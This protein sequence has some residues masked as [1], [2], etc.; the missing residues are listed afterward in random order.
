M[1][2]ADWGLDPDVPTVA[3]YLQEL[4]YATHLLGK[5]HLY[6]HTPLASCHTYMVSTIP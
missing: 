5:W 4:D 6:V 3:D 2:A 1:A